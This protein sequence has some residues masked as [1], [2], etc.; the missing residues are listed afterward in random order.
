MA[1]EKKKK[2]SRASARRKCPKPLGESKWPFPLNKWGPLPC[3]VNFELPFNEP[4][5][6][7]PQKKARTGESGAHSHT[8]WAMGWNRWANPVSGFA[9]DPGAEDGP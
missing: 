4:K 8:G 6:G 9:S 2:H 7:Y 1:V 5:Q 3:V